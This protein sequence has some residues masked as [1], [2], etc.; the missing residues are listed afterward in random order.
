MRGSFPDFHP[1]S[2]ASIRATRFYATNPVIGRAATL[3]GKTFVASA[4][5]GTR[6]WSLSTPPTSSGLKRHGPSRSDQA[7][8]PHFLVTV[9]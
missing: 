3:S 7:P 5:S 6:R 8:L 4:A 1:P 2:R 9:L